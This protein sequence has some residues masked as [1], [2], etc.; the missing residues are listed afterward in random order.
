MLRF[1]KLKITFSSVA[2]S[3]ERLKGI[4]KRFLI[5]LSMQSIH[6][7]FYRR[8]G[9]TKNWHCSNLFLSPL[10]G[11]GSDLKRNG[12]TQ[13]SIYH[14]HNHLSWSFVDYLTNETPFTHIFKHGNINK[15][16][17][18]NFVARYRSKLLSSKDWFVDTLAH[19]ISTVRSINRDPSLAISPTICRKLLILAFAELDVKI[20]PFNWQ[21]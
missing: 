4:Q 17:A 13:A 9:Q 3:I 21:S 1:T 8:Y 16:P 19:E 20:S 11:A 15:K 5:I 10:P 6:K 2:L 18:I 14:P 12:G 7:K